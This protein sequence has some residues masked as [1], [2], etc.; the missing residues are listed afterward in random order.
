MVRLSDHVLNGTS[1]FCHHI[2]GKKQTKNCNLAKRNFVQKAM[3][4]IWKDNGD[5]IH[6]S[7]AITKEAKLLY[8]NLYASRED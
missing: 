7:N 6:D 8:E 5:I 4:F 2:E 1:S 3:Y